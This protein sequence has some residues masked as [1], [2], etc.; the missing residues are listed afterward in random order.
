MRPGK[1]ALLVL[2]AL[3]ALI[4]FGLTGGGGILLWAHAT[5]RDAGGYYQSSTE[6]FETPTHALT[7]EHID[8]RADLRDG[9]WAAFDDIGTAR[10]SLGQLPRRRSSSASPG[11]QTSSG[12]CPPART[13]S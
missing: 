2:G 13:T 7:S 3:S 5:Q 1:I 9:D 8:L 10:S 12:S 11:T 4:G 6:R